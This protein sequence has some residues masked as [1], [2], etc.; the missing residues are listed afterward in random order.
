MWVKQ[1]WT[2]GEPMQTQ[3]G[4]IMDYIGQKLKK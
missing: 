3:D 2:T 1:K 4:T